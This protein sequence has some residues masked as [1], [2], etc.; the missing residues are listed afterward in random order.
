VTSIGLRL[1]DIGL[2]TFLASDSTQKPTKDVV[3]VDRGDSPSVASQSPLLS[4]ASTPP[5]DIPSRAQSPIW[6][7]PPL[8]EESIQRRNQSDQASRE[9]GQRM[10]R[11]W[12]MLADECPN[13]SCFGIPLVRPPPAVHSN[14]V[15]MRGF[16]L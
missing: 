8:S 2:M 14:K 7:L 10:L 6:E 4:R 12:A 11:G 3:K 9:I 15:G 16:Y 1:R 5:T 13:D